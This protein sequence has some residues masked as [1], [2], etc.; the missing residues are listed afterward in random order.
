MGDKIV[1]GAVAGIEFTQKVQD[2][3]VAASQV[4]SRLSGR[5]CYNNAGVMT[6]SDSGTA[7]DAWAEQNDMT[8]SSTSGGTKIAFDIS[9]MKIYEVPIHTDAGTAQTEAN[10][11]AVMFKTCDL[12]VASSIQKADIEESNED[13]ITIVGYNVTNQ[14]VLVHMNPAKVRQTGVA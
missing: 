7:V 8:S 2:M 12:V 10:L 9:C 4:F 11:Q 5:F 13:V 1:Y 3:P 6:V 14:T